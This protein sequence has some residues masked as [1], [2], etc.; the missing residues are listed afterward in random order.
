MPVPTYDQFIEP[1]LR[2]LAQHQDGAPARDAHEAAAAA[3]QLSDADRAEVLPSGTQRVY[4]NRAGWAHDRLKSGLGF[5]PVLDV[6]T[7]N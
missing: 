6:G 7:G 3:L 5:Q 2:Y 4:K 1:I